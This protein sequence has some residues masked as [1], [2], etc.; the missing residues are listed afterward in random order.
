MIL[1]DRLPEAK[2]GEFE[3]EVVMQP[4]KASL[5]LEESEEVRA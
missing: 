5:D 2:A 3:R 4:A 1:I